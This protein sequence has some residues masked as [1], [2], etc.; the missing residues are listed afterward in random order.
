LD[1][2]IDVA[3]NFTANGTANR[4]PNQLATSR[5]D[6]ITVNLLE[7][8][9][10]QQR[11]RQIIS[12][13]N[14]GQVS[15]SGSGNIPQS[16]QGTVFL[17]TGTTTGSRGGTN[18]GG[19]TALIPPNSVAGDSFSQIN[20]SRRQVLAVKLAT[21]AS[22][23]CTGRVYWGGTFNSVYPGDPTNK[24]IGIKID[25]DGVYVFAHNGTTYSESTNL[26]TVTANLIYEF[27]VISDG[28]GNVSIYN[29]T[30]LLGSITGGP[31]GLISPPAY[32]TAGATIN[33]NA[34][35]TDASLV[36]IS[37]AILS[38]EIYQ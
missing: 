36:L 19:N 23:G 20:F 37:V 3:G 34:T 8:I 25:G 4:L 33:N 9:S 38:G 11:V 16:N 32:A 18:S 35:T 5:S 14:F 15:H 21:S 22:A 17:R 28:N 13:N 1:N 12:G 7:L 29:G 26:M 24:S 6:L 27:S 10:L 31:T 2:S 30:T